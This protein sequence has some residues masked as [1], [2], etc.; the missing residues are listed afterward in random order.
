E[1]AGD[2][3]YNTYFFRFPELYIM[4]AE[5]LARTGSSIA[6][7][8]API[9][10][11]RSIRTN[12]V[13]PSLNPVDQQEL[14]DAIFLEY[15]FETFLENGNEFYASLRFDTANGNPWIETT[16]NGKSLKINS[17]CYP[18]PPSEMVTNQLMIQN[19]DLE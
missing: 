1:E 13:I 9:N 4:K 19:V 5:L 8:I 18:I 17:I 11:M 15:F 14:M 12:P 7:A 2:F 16:K 3:K 10:T 6:D